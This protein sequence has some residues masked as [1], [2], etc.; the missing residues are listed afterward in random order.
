M[1]LCSLNWPVTIRRMENDDVK[2]CGLVSDG[3]MIQPVCCLITTGMHHLA[4]PRIKVCR[5]LCT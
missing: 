4:I 1:V 5:R 2:Y 3:Y